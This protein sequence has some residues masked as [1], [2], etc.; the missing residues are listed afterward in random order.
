MLALFFADVFLGNCLSH[1]QL[2]CFD[3]LERPHDPCLSET[4]SLLMGRIDQLKRVYSMTCSSNVFFKQQSVDPKPS[5]FYLQWSELIASNDYLY[6]SSWQG[7]N[8]LIRINGIR[9]CD[10]MLFYRHHKQN[11]LIDYNGRGIK[12]LYWFSL[13]KVLFVQRHQENAFNISCTVECKYE[14]YFVLLFQ[15]FYITV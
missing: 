10:S 2:S 12:G 5:R 9:V 14:K 13:D 4:C 8:H 1:E 3:V 7:S 11:N 15:V 6:Q